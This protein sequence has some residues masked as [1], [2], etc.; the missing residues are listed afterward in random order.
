MVNK[1]CVTNTKPITAELVDE[2]TDE[3][4]KSIEPENEIRVNINLTNQVNSNNRN[5]Q[6]SNTKKEVRR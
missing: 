1:A 3:I 2:L 4:Y 5:N 6:T